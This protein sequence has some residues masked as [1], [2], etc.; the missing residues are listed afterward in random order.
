VAEAKLVNFDK[1]VVVMFEDEAGFGRIADP[2]ACWAPAPKRPNC[3]SL[4]IRQFKTVYG[5]VCPETGERMFKIYSTN[6]TQIMNDFL[7][8]LSQKFPDYY[9]ILCCDNAGWHKAKDLEKP[10]NIEMFYLPPYTPEMNPIE[11]IWKE[12]RKRGFK[13]IM[14]NSLEAVVEKFN[15]I[16]NNLKKSTIQS[17]TQRDWIRQAF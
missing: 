3:P 16:I 8:A 15:E 17:I 10:E 14:F 13:N 7:S 1:K 12:I 9:I 11:Q 4:R 2:A 5:A 6:N